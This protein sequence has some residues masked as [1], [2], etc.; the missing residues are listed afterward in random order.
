MEMEFFNKIRSIYSLR[1]PTKVFIENRVQV[2]EWLENSPNLHPIENLWRI[3]KFRLRKMDCTTVQ[4]LVEAIVEVWYHDREIAQ[5][6]KK[7][8]ESM[9]NDV[10]DL[11][12]ASGGHIKY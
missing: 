10:N 2:L 7:L 4:K 8:V 1:K 6:C 5:K 9:S 3:I 12:K 11:F